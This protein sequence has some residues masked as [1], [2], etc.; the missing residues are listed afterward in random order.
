MKKI[1]YSLLCALS[2]FGAATTAKAELTPEVNVGLLLHTYVQAQQE[3][4]GQSIEQITE[5]ASD[6]SYG[7]N[8]YRARVLFDAK[9]TDKDYIFI[10]TDLTASVGLGSDKAASIKI[11]DAQ[12]DHKFSDALTLSAG[13]I[14]VSHN[15][16]GL[17]T[18]ATLMAN[19]FSYFQYAYNMGESS[20]LENDCGR[21]IGLNLSGAIIDSKLKYRIGAFSGNRTLSETMPLRF[22]GRLQYDFMDSDLYSGTNLGEGETLTVAAGFDTQGSYY[23]VGADAYLD[24]PAGDAGSITANMAYSYITGGDADATYSF[25]S[26]V[27]EQNVLFA[28]LGYYFK[29]SKLQPWVKYEL[30]NKVSSALY[31]ETVIGGGLNYFYNG[32]GSNVR[33]SYIARENSSVDK[34]YGQVWLQFQIFIF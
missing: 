4:F 12:Y 30:Q 14:L 34:F 29:K 33:V 28:E 11:L 21:D 24:L 6:M 5:S 15:R 3:G 2:V 32:Y 16:N 25:S 19:D 31:D 13:K 26:L 17:Q 23:A 7:A 18:A 1:I 22:V 27:D 10:E 9:L 20:A 8:L